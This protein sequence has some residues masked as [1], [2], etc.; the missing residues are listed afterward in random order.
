MEEQELITQPWSTLERL[1]TEGNPEEINIFLNSLS[2]AETA[3]SV[4]HMEED[5]RQKLLMLLNPEDAADVLQDLPDEQ[6]ADIIEDMTPEGAAAIMDQMSNDMQADILSDI[7]P[8]DV[9]AILNA[10]PWKEAQKTRQLLE[11]EED[12]AGAIM[13][14]TFLAYP[15]TLS[16]GSVV[17]DMRKKSDSY[18]D[19]DVQYVYITSSKGK[20]IG[21]LRLRDL[22]LTAP[23]KKVNTIMIPDPVSVNVYTDL[24]D[25][26][27]MFDE[28]AYLGVPVTDQQG[29]LVGIVRRGQV[30]E[31]SGRRTENSFLKISGIVGGEEFRYMPFA[32]RSF[33]RLSWLSINI[34]LNII[35]ASV[36]AI[37]QETLTAVI[38]LAVFLPII[39]DMS[40]CSGNQA[41]AVSIRELTLGLI[42]PYEIFRVLL[43]E[44]WIGLVN[45]VILGSLLG[46]VAFLWKG[47]PFLGLVVGGALATNT[48]VAVSLGG[49]IPLILKRTGMDP[50]LASSPILTTVTDMCGFFF[51]LS[52]ATL[53]LPLLK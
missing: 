15:E 25:L 29:I 8:D 34:I 11:Y 7:D 4:S 18:S 52:F 14:T 49:M 45:G 13:S 20:L 37:Y 33:R 48:I 9:E 43:K 53:A 21:V 1:L 2:P 24:D 28:H 46:G 38:A 36:I 5:S 30:L 22:L 26:I 40:G 39:S 32:Q 51:A 35:A 12:S 17:S 16:C 44:M 23:E 19:Y 31:A 42:K 27:A 3:R 10:M 41:V 6:A 47:N 50:A